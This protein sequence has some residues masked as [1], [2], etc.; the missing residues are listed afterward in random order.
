MKFSIA[1]T[2]VSPCAAWARACTSLQIFIFIFMFWILQ[3]MLETLD[4]KNMKQFSC[5]TFHDDVFGKYSRRRCRE[6]FVKLKFAREQERKKHKNVQIQLSKR[7]TRFEW[8]R[9]ARSVLTLL[10]VRNEILRS[11]GMCWVALCCVGA[12]TSVQWI[13]SHTKCVLCCYFCLFC[14]NLQR[15]RFFPINCKA[16]SLSCHSTCGPPRY[17]KKERKRSGVC[18]CDSLLGALA[19][20][21][22]P[23]FY[24][25]IS[26]C[27]LFS[28]AF[29]IVPGYVCF[30]SGNLGT[31]TSNLIKTLSCVLVKWDKQ[32]INK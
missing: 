32:G 13:L 20:R 4:T 6:P 10:C 31:H 9:N 5:Y 21:H 24:F 23:I 15:K 17:P 26:F 19:K 29:S 30:S 1:D 3:Q 27:A 28:S 12:A 22:F 16:L 18:V 25:G 7:Y 8:N 14:L 11:V 2:P